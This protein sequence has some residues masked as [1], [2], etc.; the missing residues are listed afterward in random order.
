MN[1]NAYY[2]K[3]TKSMNCMKSP[4]DLGHVFGSIYNKIFNH[5]GM[6]LYELRIDRFDFDEIMIYYNSFVFMI[7]ENRSL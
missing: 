7:E 1:D 3:N 4:Y 2:N 5:I 6:L